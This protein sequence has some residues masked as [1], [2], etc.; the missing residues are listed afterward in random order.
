MHKKIWLLVAATNIAA[1]VS[2]AFAAE[3]DPCVTVYKE[4][5]NSIDFS[6]S[7]DALA[8]SIYRDA[9]STRNRS[10]SVGFDSSTA[11]L[12]NAV[13]VVNK[14]M[15]S[16][17][18]KNNKSFC[19]EFDKRKISVSHQE[20]LQI[21][22]AIAAQ[23]NFNICEE[24]LRSHKVVITHVSRSP[25]IVDF[26]FD[27]RTAAP[28]R[29]QGVS[30]DDAGFECYLPSNSPLRRP[31]GRGIYELK[32]NTVVKCQRPPESDPDGYRFRDAIISIGT[33][34]GIYAVNIPD[35]TMLGP[36]AKAEYQQI[37]EDLAKKNKI[38]EEKLAGATAKSYRFYTGDSKAFEKSYGPRLHGC[39]NKP[40]E[41][42]H[43]DAKSRFCPSA[44][45]FSV[46]KGKSTHSGGS[47]GYHYYVI[48][49]VTFPPG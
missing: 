48:D 5:V 24:I 10:I 39:M 29:I 9:C 40:R 49:C 46:R 2:Y 28:F 42:V 35:T 18:A 25:A 32:S 1:N 15:G 26:H 27:F 36:K 12:V 31:L 20:Y 47:C 41:K 4:A 13:P 37:V 3:A 23:E 34:A 8:E 17:G 21:Q 44:E 30:T 45:N 33:D 16:F 6:K 22:P 43:A 7:Y 14:M 11:T 38:L 19:D